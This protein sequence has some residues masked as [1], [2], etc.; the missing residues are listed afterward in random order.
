MA[1]KKKKQAYPKKYF[2]AGFITLIVLLLG[3]SLGII[4]DN[5]RVSYIENLNANEQVNFEDLQLQSS[6]LDT[7]TLE[8]SSRVCDVF[9]AAIE[10]SVGLLSDSLAKVE[11]YSKETN[12]N[13]EDYARIQKK[14]IL[15]NIRYWF[16]IKN[17]KKQCRMNTTTILY[18]YNQKCKICPNQ[19]VILSYYK[20]IY[21]NNL[22]VFPINDDY[23]DKLTIIKLI[24]KQYNVTGY[25]T[26]IVDDKVYKGI[27]GTEQLGRILKENFN[28]LNDE[29]KNTT[30]ENK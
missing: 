20:K 3:I 10:K 19:G 24:K 14:Y 17:A 29:R 16:L 12:I 6:Y 18:F 7:L 27:V 15:D 28:R 9:Q 5:V 11:E 30:K 4:V 22:L 23:G 8:N 2:L 13:Q 21:G 1:V 25:P 26:I